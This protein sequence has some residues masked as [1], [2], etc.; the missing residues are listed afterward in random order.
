VASAVRGLL[1]GRKLDEK[2]ADQM[3]ADF[4][5]LRIVRHPMAPCLP[6]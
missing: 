1:I 2:R 4:V 5:A 3:L 6:G